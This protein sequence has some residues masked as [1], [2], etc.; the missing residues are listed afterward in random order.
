[1]G[2]NRYPTI[3]VRRLLAS[4]PCVP[5]GHYPTPIDDMQRFGAA[6]GSGTRLLVKR[7]DAIAFGFGGNKVR[8]AQLI[9]AEAL[10]AGADTLITTG[11]VQS[12]HARV[13][14]AAAA[15]LGLRCVLVANGTRPE[16]LTANALLDALLGA[17]VHYVATRDERAPAMEAI[18]ANLAAEGRHPFI[19]P[20]GAST[21]TGA[22]GFVEAIVE[23][24]EQIDPPDVIVHSTSSGGTQAGLIAGAALLG[25]P[26]RIIGVSADD[27][28]A[29]LEER[30]LEILSGIETRLSLEPDTLCGRATIEVD[31]RFVGDGYGIATPASHEAMTLAARTEAL[32]VDSTYTAKAL[33]G[34][35]SRLRAGEFAHSTTV[36][37][38]HTGGQVGIF[39]ERWEHTRADRVRNPLDLSPV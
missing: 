25:L 1:M 7:D 13:T 28:A 31:D 39:A 2:A 8:K 32:F 22:L 16:P 34:L 10:A 18:A 11:G 9:A 33:A 6:L 29:A 12:N 4:V 30:I 23:L 15:R 37:F 26:T 38:W 5:L 14:A 24:V 27:P 20:L 35:V 17:E 21:P 19:I 36:L 3:E